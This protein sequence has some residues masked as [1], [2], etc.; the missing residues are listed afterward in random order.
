[1]PPWGNDGSVDMVVADEIRHGSYQPRP[2]NVPLMRLLWFLF[3]VICVCLS[4]L[5]V[6]AAAAAAS[7]DPPPVENAAGIVLEVV[8][9]FE[10]EK[11][12]PEEMNNEKERERERE[13]EKKNNKSRRERH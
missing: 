10:I 2:P 8:K 6:A 5:V 11:K 12:E 1:M 4:V 3:G 13:R 7:P 9:R